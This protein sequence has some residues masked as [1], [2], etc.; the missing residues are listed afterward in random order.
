MALGETFDLGRIYAQ[1]EAI[2]SARS[3]REYKKNYMEHLNEQERRHWAKMQQENQFKT[4]YT[5]IVQVE[6]MPE[7]QQREWLAKQPIGQD[8]RFKDAPTA[9]VIQAIKNG[10]LVGL[11]KN[12]EGPDRPNL[13]LT[14]KGYLPSDQAQGLQPPPPQRAEPGPVN[15]T[16]FEEEEM[17]G[18]KRY[19]RTVVANPR[20]PHER[21]EGPWREVA[22]TDPD[23]WGLRS[24]MGQDGEETPDQQ[25]PPG[26]TPGALLPG[27]SV[28]DLQ[29]DA[30][31]R[32]AI[33]RD[34]K[35]VVVGQVP[36]Q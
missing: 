27:E 28:D 31:G 32:I 11:D 8:P 18:G 19:K 16:R 23:P 21:R 36:Q 7:E 25:L 5:E 6:A 30:K 24:G 9:D 35:W 15:W 2:K 22:M 1:A 3:D 17:R 12:P 20:P 26:V 4:M 14:E 33:Q 10:V 29:V 13:Y 34:G